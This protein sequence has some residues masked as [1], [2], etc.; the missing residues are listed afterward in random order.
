MNICRRKRFL[1]YLI[2]VIISLG[3]SFILGEAF[4]RKIFSINTGTSFLYR[5]P[6]P[7]LGWV[8]EPG[9]SYANRMP[10]TTVRVTYNSAGWRDVEH[11]VSNPHRVF[12]VLVLGDSY[13]EAYSVELED[14]FHR[15]LEEV[16][17]KM[18]SDIEVINLGVGGYGTLQEYLAFREMGQLYKPDL[19]LLGFYIKND[20]RNNS[21]EIESIVSTGSIKVQSRPFLDTTSPAVWRITQIDFE[22]ARRR[23]AAAKARRNTFR[24]RLARQSALVQAAERATVRIAQMMSPNSEQPPKPETEIS[25]ADQERNYLALYGVNFCVEPPEYTRAWDTTARILDRLKHDI[26]AID[27]RL[28]VFTVPA[29]SDV[30]TPDMEQVKARALSADKLCLNEAPGYNRLKDVLKELNIDFVDLLPNFRNVM[31]DRGTN[32]FRHSDRHWNPAGHALAA[33]LV[34]AALMEKNRLPLFR[35]SETVQQF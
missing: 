31:R 8:L 1:G 2:R 18:G 20:V 35:K 27:S 29:L 24:K 11:T 23:Y 3:M 21:F 26:E 22:G 10:E 13:I 33:N 25:L 34:V 16:A 19:V 12:R 15:R 14:A 28:F 32:L 7:V 5:I 9:V 17:H 4:L 6:H 30:S